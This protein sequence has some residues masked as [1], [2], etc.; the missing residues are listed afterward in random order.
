MCVFYIE[1]GQL[2][3]SRLNNDHSF[4]IGYFYFSRAQRIK[5]KKNFLF[6][7]L[8][9]EGAFLI[10]ILQLEMK[11]TEL[12]VK[13]KN[14]NLTQNK[15]STKSIESIDKSIDLFPTRKM[16]TLDFKLE[17]FFK[18]FSTYKHLSKFFYIQL[19]YFDEK[20]LKEIR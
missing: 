19:I 1:L 20:N 9:F 13:N 10:Y 4:A 11:C 12:I 2:N 8:V 7:R 16:S 15:N 5:Y 6:F 17:S 14:K 18:P 3:Y